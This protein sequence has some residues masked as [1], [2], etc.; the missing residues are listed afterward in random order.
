MVSYAPSTPPPKGSMKKTKKAQKAQLFEQLDLIE[1]SPEVAPPPPQRERIFPV[2]PCPAPRM[3]QSD[4]WKV[5]DKARPVVKRY[6]K[7]CDDLRL[8]AQTWELPDVFAITFVM[9]MPK[10]WSKKRR[11]DMDGRPQKSTPDLDN[12]L[13]GFTDALREQD[14]EIHQVLAR[15]IWGETGEVRVLEFKS[16]LLTF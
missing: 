12:L 14:K 11:N 6:R 15:K 1:D 3:T 2:V 7:Y 16:A 9:P 4:Q 8:L 5:G 13:K 10:S